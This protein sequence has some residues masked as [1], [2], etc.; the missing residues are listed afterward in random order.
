[1]SK[2][3]DTPNLGY[4]TQDREIQDDELEAVTGGVVIAII[5][6]LVG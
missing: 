3:N 4:A 6:V 5:S 1:M 2:T